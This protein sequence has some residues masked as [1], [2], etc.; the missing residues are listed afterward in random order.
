MD[1]NYINADLALKTAQSALTDNYYL[2]AYSFAS[3]H[4]P[5]YWFALSLIH[6]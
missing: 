3:D 6:I 2:G 4:S 1:M 5:N